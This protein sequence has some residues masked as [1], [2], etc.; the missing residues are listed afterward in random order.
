[1]SFSRAYVCNWQSFFIADGVLVQQTHHSLCE[2]FLSS[3]F[4]P[5]CNQSIFWIDY[6]TTYYLLETAFLYYYMAGSLSAQTSLTLKSESTIAPAPEI[7]SHLFRV[8]THSVCFW[9]FPYCQFTSLMT[10]GERSAEESIT[11]DRR[12]GTPEY[13]PC[14]QFPRNSCGDKYVLF[15]S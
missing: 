7:P 2:Y 10:S 3:S 4:V 9:K 13:H 1:M 14:L 15:L 11:L 6:F 5:V 12:S 8:D